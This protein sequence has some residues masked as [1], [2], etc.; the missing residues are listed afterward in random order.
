MEFSQIFL[1]VV[2]IVRPSA[3][4]KSAYEINTNSD[5]SAELQWASFKSE[6]KKH[7]ADPSE[8]VKLQKYPAIY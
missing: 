7:Y 2:L 4:G 3:L 5:L 8:E 6:N 1:F